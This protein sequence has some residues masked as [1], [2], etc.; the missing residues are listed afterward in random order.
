MP[1][2]ELAFAVNAAD[3]IWRHFL[4]RAHIV[5]PYGKRCT[6]APIAEKKSTKLNKIGVFRIKSVVYRDFKNEEVVH[7]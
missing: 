4:S 5:H 2:T 3:T 1:V 6:E 7:Q